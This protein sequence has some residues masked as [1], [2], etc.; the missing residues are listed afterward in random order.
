MFGIDVW[1]FNYSWQSQVVYKC[2]HIFGSVFFSCINS[3]W[4]YNL[5]DPFTW[6]CEQFDWFKKSRVGATQHKPQ[7]IFGLDILKQNLENSK[8]RF[9]R[10]IFSLFLLNEISRN[11]RIVVPCFFSNKCNISLSCNCEKSLF[12]NLWFDY[13]NYWR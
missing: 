10:W 11:N 9:R 4:V 2:Y 12:P 3:L 6:A 5:F 7:T 8:L 1:T 13:N